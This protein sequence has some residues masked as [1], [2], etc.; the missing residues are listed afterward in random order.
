M[1]SGAAMRGYG[2]AMAAPVLLR[3]PSSLEHDTGAH[4]ERPSGSSRSSATL[5]RA[6]LARLGRARVARGAARACSGRAPGGATSSGS[7]ALVRGGRRARSTSTRS[8][9]PG[10]CEAALHGGGRRGARSSTRCS[11]TG[12][13]SARSAAPAARP[14]R[15]LDA[16]DGLLPVQQRRGRRAARARRAR[17]RARAHPR[18][19]RAPRQRDQ[20]HLPRA[21]PSVL[22]VLDPR[23]AAV[24]GDRSGRATSA[25]GGGG[26]HGQPARAGRLG[27]RDLVLARR[28]R[29]ACRS[30]RAYAPELVLLSAGY[31]AHA[32]RP[33]RGLRGHARRATPRW[34]R[35]CARSPTSSACR[36]GWCSRAATTCGR[37]RSRSS[38]RS[39]CSA[40][41]RR[42]PTREVALHPLAGQAATRLAA[43]W[44]LVGTVA[45]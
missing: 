4:P 26:L 13:A 6:R 35:A 22:F 30:A 12:A 18:L 21:A 25:R 5:E 39:R 28:A 7:R 40:P 10:S 8:C 24:S 3:H 15:E 1:R 29:R 32:R 23:V 20:R 38:R 45:G 43:R 44:P 9:R 2:N 14:P 11:A 27:R 31:D 36:S 34:R 41:T 42:P 19:G 16:R 33:A 17:R 37:W